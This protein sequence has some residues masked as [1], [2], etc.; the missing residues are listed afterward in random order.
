MLELV[1]LRLNRCDDPALFAR[2]IRTILDNNG[3]KLGGQ[4]T[5]RDLAGHPSLQ[6]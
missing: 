4:G 3:G 2:A 5:V 6:T 1:Q